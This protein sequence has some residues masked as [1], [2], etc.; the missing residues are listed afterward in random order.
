M[1]YAVEM[2]AR[3][4][5]PLVFLAGL[6]VLWLS[7]RMWFGSLRP[8]WAASCLIGGWSPFASAAL[9]RYVRAIGARDDRVLLAWLVRAL[10][11]HFVLAWMIGFSDWL[12]GP[13]D[14]A[15]AWNMDLGAPLALFSFVPAFALSL[16]ILGW[17]S[18]LKERLTTPVFRPAMPGERTPRWIP[19]RGIALVRDGAPRAAVPVGPVLIGAIGLATAMGLPA[20]PLWY[21][22]A[23]ALPLSIATVRNHRALAPSLGIL[24][25]LV[26][27]A[28]LQRHAGGLAAGVNLG[29]A[30]PWLA[31]AVV[32]GYLAT[33]E[34][35]LLLRL[36]GRAAPTR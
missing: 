19:F 3:S 30:S 22:P 14:H 4:L 8:V 20:A 23:C 2:R 32:A 13:P 36:W 27:T 33:V 31:M 25:A 17:V 16:L 1:R 29:V 11:M 6:M 10:G 15:P 35:A 26:L 5:V 9:F 12:R 24:T 34:A 18:A 7:T 28:M 21:L